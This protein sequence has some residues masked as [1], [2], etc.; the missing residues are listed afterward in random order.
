MSVNHNQLRISLLGKLKFERNDQPLPGLTSIK[1]QALLAYL[2]VTRQ[3]CSRS[4]LAGLLW[5][6]MPEEVARTNLRVTLSHLLKAVG[7]TVIA[8]RHS[9]EFNRHSHTWLDIEALEQAARSGAG[10][11]AAAEL[12]RG[13][14]LDDFHVPEAELFEAWLLVERE[15]LRQLGL[16]VLDRV[17]G[18]ALEQG[19]FA[20]GIA[21]A[22]R[23]LAIEPWHEE[24]HR[25]LMKLLAADGQRSAALAQ[26]ETCRRL[27][28]EDLGVEPAAETVALHQALR[29]GE[30]R[31]P[32]QVQVE[33]ATPVPSIKPGGLPP[34]NLLAAAT[35]FVGRQV[36]QAKI[37]ELLAQPDCRLLTI[38]G[39]GGMGKTRL[40]LTVASGYL[41]PDTPFYNGVYFVPLAE[42][43]P[44]TGASEADS[45]P[46]VPAIG[47]AMDVPFSGQ[48][49]LKTQL[50]NAIGGKKLLLVLDNFEHLLNYAGQ[51]GEILEQAPGLKVIVT[52][53][54]RL[55][56]Y[57]EWVFDLWGLAYPTENDPTEIKAFDSLQLFEQRAR[58]VSQEFDLRVELPHVVRICRLVEGMPL[59]LELAA[60]WVRTLPCRDI[61]Q[62]IENNL[63]FLTTKAAHVSDRQHSLRAV[64]DYSWQSLEP[65]DQEVFSRLSVFRGGF[66]TKAAIEVAGASHLLLSNLV[67]KSLLQPL[68][69]GR[70]GLHELLRQ[71]GTERLTEADLFQAKHA[72]YFSHLSQQQEQALVNGETNAINLV[73]AEIDNIQVACQWAVRNADGVVLGQLLNTVV[74][75]YELRGWF[76]A[77]RDC[78]AQA[79]QAIEGEAAENL[80]LLGRLEENLARFHDHL[81]AYAEAQQHAEKSL[82]L[83]EQA[84]AP[85]HAANARALLGYVLLALGEN[86][87]GKKFLE[88]SLK[89]FEALGHLRGQADAFYYLNYAATGL[90]DLAE[91]LR[92]VEESLRRY[93]ELGDRRNTAKG[94][95]LLGNYQ[96]GFGNYARALEYYTA[97]KK[98]HQELGNRVG[99]A[100]CLRNEGLA[101]LYSG[102][103]D[104]AERAAQ[105]SLNLFIEFG[106][107]FNVAKSLFNL[108]R[109]VAG[110]ADYRLARRYLE[111]SLAQFQVRG[112]LLQMTLAHGYLGGVMVEL[113]NL[114][115][116]KTHF[117]QAL[118]L[119]M[120]AQAVLHVLDVLPQMTNF[121]V[122]Q[123]L[124]PLAI[125]ALAHTAHHPATEEFSREQARQGLQKLAM[126]GPP[127]MVARLETQGQHSSLD[128]IVTALLAALW[129]ETVNLEH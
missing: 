106:D 124:T 96:I 11:A 35:S 2:A 53:R 125:K 61:V 9:V 117:R 89:T 40:A 39:P 10:L 28:S 49:P 18:T 98:L 54:E 110:R 21:A 7:D 84:E 90:G 120:S 8:T 32:Q 102:R 88:E 45:N 126:S 105:A 30:W 17:A 19:Q 86:V 94:L 80:L 47:A 3:P 115:L 44:A 69:A 116:A 48:A 83:F 6:D 20:T 63:D 37:A 100:D 59:G 31:L 75:L 57:E 113:S 67:D 1:G 128:E 5:S 70:Y 51:V 81:G 22:R 14:F 114:N 95:H 33:T 91:G 109:V 66:T 25:Q 73:T 119:G 74:T 127:D 13:D 111:E 52:S 93:Q 27:L 41:R 65:L 79:I 42:V 56:L 77:G 29:T 12:Y 108:G 85:Y 122:G 82:H 92:C 104:E 76:Q 107:Q 62:E 72:R 50:L 123:G 64:F 121:L 46:L 97:S 16:S 34:H 24:G 99:V 129:D 58:R 112:N 78:C 15:R 36:E 26:Y 87:A 60:T 71:Y 68:E 118:E 55:N 4:A 38:T 43:S 23:L 101:A 103:L